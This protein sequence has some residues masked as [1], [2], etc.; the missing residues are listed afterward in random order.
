MSK[1]TEVIWESVPKSWC[2]IA[3]RERVAELHNIVLCTW[4]AHVIHRAYIYTCIYI[5]I[6]CMPS[7]YYMKWL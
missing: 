7:L 3:Y 1:L 6:L 2:S 5:H 4:Y